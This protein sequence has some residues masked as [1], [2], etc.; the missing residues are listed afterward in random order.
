[1]EI[2]LIWMYGQVN[3]PTNLC[4]GLASMSATTAA[5]SLSLLQCSIE[6]PKP[7]PK[8]HPK[9]NFGFPVIYC[10]WNPF[11]GSATAQIDNDLGHPATAHSSPRLCWNLWSCDRRDWWPHS[12]NCWMAKR[13]GSRVAFILWNCLDKNMEK[14]PLGI[15]AHVSCVSSLARV[16]Q[17]LCRSGLGASRIDRVRLVPV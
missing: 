4:W 16:T 2:C 5:R 17:S 1:M 9:C 3:E 7:A 8:P 13:L 12:A 10:T 11:H 14:Y 15:W 6:T